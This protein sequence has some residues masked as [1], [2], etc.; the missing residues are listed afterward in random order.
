MASVYDP[1][2]V[3]TISPVA[4]ATQHLVDKATSVASPQSFLSS[5][6]DVLTFPFRA[7]YRADKFAFTTLPRH[8]AKFVGLEGIASQLM[9][10]TSVSGAAAAAAGTQA[11]GDG[12]AGAAAA[13]GSESG[14][15]ITDFFITLKRLSGFF[16]Y[17]TSRWSLACFTVVSCGSGVLVSARQVWGS[18]NAKPGSYSE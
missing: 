1:E 3:S 18:N 7:I 6:R 8:I 17:L 11:A 4:T 12:M 5:S 13:T 14:S 2:V 15:F 9:E 10:D 16:S